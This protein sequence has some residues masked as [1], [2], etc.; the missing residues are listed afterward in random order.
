MV[1]FLRFHASWTILPALSARSHLLLPRVPQALKVVNGQ[2]ACLPALFW[3]L[4]RRI[5]RS[6]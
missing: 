6:R 3:R 4:S 5:R 2:G 1:G